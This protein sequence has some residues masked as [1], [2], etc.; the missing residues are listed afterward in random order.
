ME[1]KNQ[2]VVRN[3][4]RL[5]LQEWGEVKSAPCKILSKRIDYKVRELT[6]PRYIKC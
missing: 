5:N 6:S 2:K 1:K 3:L 4:I